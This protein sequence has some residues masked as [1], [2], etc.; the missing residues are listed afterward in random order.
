VVLALL[1]VLDEI[2]TESSLARA[3]SLLDAVGAPALEAVPA[4]MIAADRLHLTWK[5]RWYGSHPSD[6]LREVARDVR[7]IPAAMATLNDYVTHSHAGV[8]RWALNALELIGEPG[9]SC[10]AA[11]LTMLERTPPAEDNDDRTQILQALAA[12]APRDRSIPL[13][14]NALDH[15]PTR[16]AAVEL[17]VKLHATPQ[18][19][20][21]LAERGEGDQAVTAEFLSSAEWDD[22]ELAPVLRS[23]CSA[24]DRLARIAAAAALWR[25]AQG[26][27][28]T[29]EV[30]CAAL[31]DPSEEDCSQILPLFAQMGSDAAPLVPA[32]RSAILDE[33]FSPVFREKLIYRLESLGPARLALLPRLL[34]VMTDQDVETAVRRAAARQASSWRDLL[35]EPQ[36]AV[37]DP[38]LRAALADDVDEVVAT[39]AVEI[40]RLD[41]ADPKPLARLVERVE[42]SPPCASEIILA[43]AQWGADGAPAVPG[44]IRHLRRGFAGTYTRYAL[45]NVGAPALPALRDLAARGDVNQQ[46]RA[47]AAIEAIERNIAKTKL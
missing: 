5:G 3:M 44:L 30:L 8:R 13:L 14:M 7:A 27:H 21:I 20:H 47:Q 11:L 26:S 17:L 24:E 32:L 39:A 29:L 41:A 12:A 22:R 16:D 43:V 37:L 31:L 33:R 45:V 36:R 40:H 6:R 18:L 42:A 35:P 10:E 38:T 4:V 25:H 34:D 19:V 23:L 2:E 15:P 9:R 46:K 28:E 1:P